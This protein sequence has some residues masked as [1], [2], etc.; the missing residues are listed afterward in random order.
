MNS[1]KKN[2]LR[3]VLKFMRI[4]DRHCYESLG[5]SEN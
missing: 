1:D 3:T 4:I 5:I 2:D